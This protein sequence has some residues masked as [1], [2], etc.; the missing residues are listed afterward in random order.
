MNLIFLGPPGAGKGTVAG[1]AARE[2]SI[3][4][5]S[6]GDLFREAIKN[7]TPLGLKVKSITEA[8]DLVPD[9]LTIAL[10]RE[11]LEDDDTDGGFIID[12]FPR[13]IPQAEA[14]ESFV[15]VSRVLNFV[16]LDEQVI[17]RLSGRRV[18][19]NCGKTYHVL[20]MPSQKDG[21]CDACSGELY[22]RKDDSVESIKNR[23]D[24]YKKQ[25]FPLVEFYKKRGL[26]MDIDASPEA[27][28]VYGTAK[29]ILGTLE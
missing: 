20:Y 8:G 26:V 23:L 12:G 28:E 19:K 10:V 3:P 15:K 7:Q 4:H 16:L 14:F 17:E 27:E 21:I 11:R 22:T 1:R 29:R 24:V 2:F 25:T 18:C 5:I 9:E 13:T 6:T